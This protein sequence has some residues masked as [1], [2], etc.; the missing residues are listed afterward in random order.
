MAAG[1]QFSFKPPVPCH[2]FRRYD[3]QGYRYCVEYQLS[4]DPTHH[5][6]MRPFQE[7]MNPKPLD[8][9]GI[10]RHPKARVNAARSKVS[11]DEKNPACFLGASTTSSQKSTPTT[12]IR[13]TITSLR[14]HR[15]N[16]TRI[17]DKAI[18]RARPKRYTTP[19]ASSIVPETNHQ[20]RV[21]SC[22][23]GAKNPSSPHQQAGESRGT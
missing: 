11:S 16:P 22:S 5:M 12:C 1:R 6:M 2:F 23:R 17:P 14:G 10:E 21:F 7:P 3:A 20:L 13:K 4:V 18:V 19:P 8:T 9:D 15:K